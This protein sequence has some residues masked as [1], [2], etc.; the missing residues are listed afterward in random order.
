MTFFWANILILPRTTSIP[1]E[2]EAFNSNTAASNA[3]PNIVRARHRIDVVLPAYTTV[4]NGR[5]N[6]QR[7]T[8]CNGRRDASEGCGLTAAGGSS[9]DEV[10]HVTVLSDHLESLDG[11]G[12]AHNV[13]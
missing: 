6:E 3:A 11:F 10:G 7:T 13:G 8:Q 12:V 5:I 4:R 9:E 2:S 1:R